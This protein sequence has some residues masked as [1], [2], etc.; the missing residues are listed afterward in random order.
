[1]ILSLSLTISLS[2]NM[3]LSLIMLLSLIILLILIRPELRHQPSDL[4]LQ[5]G[6]DE[7]RHHGGGDDPEAALQHARAH[8]SH[9]RTRVRGRNLVSN[10][11]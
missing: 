4:R 7:L 10:S 3:S 8:L 11:I 6:G 5:G 2:L 9:R 1:M